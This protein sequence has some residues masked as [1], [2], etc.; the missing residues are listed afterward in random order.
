MGLAKKTSRKPTNS[1]AA[2]GEPAATRTS[3]VSAKTHG[4]GGKVVMVM[5]ELMVVLVCEDVLVWEDVQVVCKVLE[6]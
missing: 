4:A 6:V 1:V 2:M 5:V 3:E